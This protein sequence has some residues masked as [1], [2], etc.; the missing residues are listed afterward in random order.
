MAKPAHKN[1]SLGVGRMLQYTC[2]ICRSELPFDPLLE[3]KWS[4]ATNFVVVSTV[5]AFDTPLHLPRVV[6]LERHG[7]NPSRHRP[8]R[9]STL[10]LATLPPEP[11]ARS[12]CGGEDGGGD[13]PSLFPHVPGVDCSLKMEAVFSSPWDDDGASWAVVAG[14]GISLAG[15]GRG[16]A[17]KHRRTGLNL[18]AK[19][20][21]E[22]FS[23]CLVTKKAQTCWRGRPTSL[24]F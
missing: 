15:A 13:V 22:Q 7:Q 12:S 21:H 18:L 16:A 17:G 23:L 6:P 11:A 14:S 8:S 3:R 1:D 4:V 9:P 5:A 24:Q 10:F 2:A 20:R 19:R